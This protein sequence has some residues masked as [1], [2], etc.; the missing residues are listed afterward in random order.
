MNMS[1][2]TGLLVSIVFALTTGP[3]QG[4]KLDIKHAELDSRGNVY[5]SSNDGGLIWM[6][7]TNHCTETIVAPDSQ[8]VVCRVVRDQKPGEFLPTLR[9]EVY[10]KGG[11]T[12]SIEPGGAILEWHFW[13]DGRQIAIH[14]GSRAGSGIYARYDT[15]T[16]QLIEKLDK[17]SDERLLPRWAKSREQ[18]QDESVP[19]SDA[20]TR[21]RTMWIAKVL[22]QI[23]D[24]QPGMR[25]KD[26]VRA[27]TT[28]GGLSNRF[29][30]TYVSVECLYIK[31][32]V[33][34]K[35]A[36]DEQDALTEDPEDIVES[37]SQPYL[38]WSVLD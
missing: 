27:F 35:P 2:V 26:L 22:R 12:K 14:S 5:V 21:E 15:A 18:I 37:I 34:F 6:A 30:R 1:S 24:I 23:G 8:T 17:I 4:Q 38:Q 32:D 10:S 11:Q 29:Q 20:L 16:G 13:D 25:R 9:L 7:D 3:R 31:V 19:M 33:R 36:N 28:E